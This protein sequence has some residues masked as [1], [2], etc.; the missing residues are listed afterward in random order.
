MKN[1]KWFKIKFVDG[2]HIYQKAKRYFEKPNSN[3]IYFEKSN[4]ILVGWEKERI[5]S[6]E[7]LEK[8]PMK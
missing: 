1:M 4:D 8:C 2:D 5:K 3:L 6:I 7:E